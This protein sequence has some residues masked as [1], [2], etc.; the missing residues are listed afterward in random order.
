MPKR[1]K[2]YRDEDKARAYKN[3]H[4]AANYEKGDFNYNKGERYTE[5]ERDMILSHLIPDRVLA[6]LLGRSVRLMHARRCIWKARGIN[7]TFH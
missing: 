3:R 5:E 7:V 2:D 1:L 6:R 4:R